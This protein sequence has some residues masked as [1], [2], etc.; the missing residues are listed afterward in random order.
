LKERHSRHA[1]DD[2]FEQLQ[3][4]RADAVFVQHKT[5][6]ITARPG[7]SFHET[8]ADRLGDLHENDRYGTSCLQQ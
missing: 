5:S 7:E 6:S 1:R 4:F 8:A 3:P 2:L